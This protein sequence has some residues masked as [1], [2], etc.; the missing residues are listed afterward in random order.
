MTGE[1]LAKLNLLKIENL[2]QSKRFLNITAERELARFGDWQWDIP[3]E[4]AEI[5]KEI[6]RLIKTIDGD[7]SE[8]LRKYR[9]ALNEIIETENALSIQSYGIGD[10]ARN[11][12][13]SMV[14]PK[15]AK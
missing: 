10:I 12:L 3:H 8:E 14:E 9:A 6:D 15:D 2:I 4:A 13:E 1:F 7:Q 5:D 11:A